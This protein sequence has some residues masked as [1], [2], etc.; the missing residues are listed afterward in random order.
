MADLPIAARDRI[1][2]IDIL[3]GLIIFLMVFVNDISGVAGTPT[4]LKHFPPGGDGM[5]IVD[6]VFPGF[7]FVMGMSI[8][9]AIG[10]RLAK[11]IR[12]LSI[13]PHVIARTAALLVI[14]VFMV[15]NPDDAHIGMRAGLWSLFMY[16]SVFLVWHCIPQKS[17]SAVRFSSILRWMGIL[18]LILLAVAFRD[19]EGKWLR[20]Q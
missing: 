2:S 13:L 9:S 3:R 5:T 4:W 11:G 10:K 16:V 20:T 12:P 14:G 17:N 18:A 1:H 6:L 7:L 8:P 19:A 15:N